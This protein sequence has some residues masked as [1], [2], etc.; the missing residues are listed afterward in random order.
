MPPSSLNKATNKRGILQ[1]QFRFRDDLK[2]PLRATLGNMI[3]ATV[4]DGDS[5]THFDSAQ[6]R[7]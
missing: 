4:I 6:S 2:M 5:R 3:S 1:H 7:L